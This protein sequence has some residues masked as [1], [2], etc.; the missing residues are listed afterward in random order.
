MGQFFVFTKTYSS[1]IIRNKKIFLFLVCEAGV[2]S[3]SHIR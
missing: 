3:A 2:F 1:Y